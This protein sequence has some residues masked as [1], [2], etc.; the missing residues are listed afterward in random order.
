MFTDM[1]NYSGMMEDDEERTLAR[2]LDVREKL[3]D[4]QIEIHRGTI[5]K[6]TGDGLMVEFRSA[7]EAVRCAIEMQRDLAA[8]NAGTPGLA[9]IEI[10]VSVHAGDVMA[11]RDDI[12][13][14]GVNVAA[15]LQEH[16]EPGGIVI[17]SAVREQVGA[18]EAMLIEPLGGLR[19]KNLQREVEAFRVSDAPTPTPQ[20]RVGPPARQPSVAVL[21][22]RPIADDRSDDYFIDGIAD[23][24]VGA[25]AS[26][27]ELLVISRASTLAYRNVNMDLRVLGRRI[28]ARYLVLGSARRAGSNVHLGVELT[29]S[30]TGKLLWSN[31]YEVPSAQLFDMQ[32]DVSR[33]I[34]QALIPN[35]RGAEL[36]RIAA[37]RPENFDAYD[38]VLQAMYGLYGLETEAYSR[39]IVQLQRAIQLDPNYAAAYSLS[40]HWYMMRIGQG[41]SAD[42]GGDAAA[43]M[44]FAA[45][46]VER[47]PRDPMALALY[48]HTKAWLLHDFDAALE[49]FDQALTAYPNSA[50]VWAWSSPTYSYIGD[51]ARAV[52]HAQYALRLSPLDPYAYYFRGALSLAHYVNGTYE[53]SVRWG[54]RTMAVN[55]RYTA[56]LRFLAA[57]LAASGQRDEAAKIGRALMAIDPGFRVGPFCAAYA[58]KDP[59][60]REAFA[61][62]LRLAGLSD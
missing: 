9:P 57:A 20:A 21:P 2:W 58:F 39:S 32:D 6:G 62:H 4:R 5:V 7:I 13:G 19:L 18:A 44:R 43:A 55:P 24:I 38:L 35:L 29:D 12:Y 61:Q 3:L 42:A 14:D 28:G 15:R 48:G 49:I 51:G 8:T 46:A 17:S 30:E 11:T 16:A 22:F 36:R 53:E 56:N 59:A 47:D 31:R 34:V 50:I 37:K 27:P 41:G 1:V 54:R 45:A 52:E 25:L 60:R 23:E 33:R 40:A 10:R 26:V